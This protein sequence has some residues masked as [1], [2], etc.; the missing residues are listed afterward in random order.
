MFELSSEM[1]QVIK[2][3]YSLFGKYSTPEHF[4]V[5][6][7][8]CVNTRQE[9]ELRALP[10]SSLSRDLIYVYNDSAKD[11]LDSKDEVAY[12]LPRI[13]ELIALG[14]EIH[15]SP[16]LYLDWMSKTPLEQWTEAEK[17]LL[18]RFALQYTK[19]AFQQAKQEQWVVEIDSI[20][21]M[22]CHADIDIQAIL[23]WL[24]QCTDDIVVASIAFLVGS[25]IYEKNYLANPF[26]LDAPEFEGIFNQWFSQNLEQ[27]KQNAGNLIERPEELSKMHNNDSVCFHIEQGLLEI[28]KL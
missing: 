18:E 15:H 13:L 27:F 22:F 25:S 6:T 2:D 5:C 26:K 9:Y 7:H 14:E 28:L 24:A 21:I 17:E 1:Q 10:L 20:L 11:D 12:L 8:C 4:S 23:D 3:A 16:E 19:D